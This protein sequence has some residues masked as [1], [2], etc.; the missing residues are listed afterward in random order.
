VT[1]ATFVI[2]LAFTF[3][4]MERAANVAGLLAGPA[5]SVS[6]GLLCMCVWFHP[7]LGR[8]NSSAPV[9][10]FLPPFVQKS[11]RWYFAAFLTVW[12]LFGV[13]VWPALVLCDTVVTMRWSGP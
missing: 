11:L 4:K 8:L 9:F 1:A 13:V 10:R 12:F 7:T 6:W 5:F 3:M 2:M